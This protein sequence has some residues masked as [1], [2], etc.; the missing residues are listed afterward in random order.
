MRSRAHVARLQE[1]LFLVPPVPG[2]THPSGP[3]PAR[4]HGRDGRGD[5]SSICGSGSY[6]FDGWDPPD[7][8]DDPFN[9]PGFMSVQ[10]WRGRQPAVRPRYSDIHDVLCGDMDISE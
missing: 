8:D 5:V 9:P 1:M 7:D 6:D 4:R 2:G 10:S 3:S